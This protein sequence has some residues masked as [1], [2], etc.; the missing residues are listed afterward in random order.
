MGSFINAIIEQMDRSTAGS[1]E[2]TRKDLQMRKPAKQKNS[3][4]L[5]DHVFTTR[6][7]EKD[8]GSQVLA[9]FGEEQRVIAAVGA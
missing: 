7:I 4:F 3:L 9:T 8:T 1:E 6:L 2:T 5:G